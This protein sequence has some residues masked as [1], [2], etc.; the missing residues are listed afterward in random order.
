MLDIRLVRENPEIIEANLKKRFQEDKIR[1]LGELIAKDKKRREILQ[2]VETLKRDRNILTKEIS[3]LKSQK[4]PAEN[5][6]AE[7]KKVADRIKAM[8]EDL[9]K[10]AAECNGVLMRLPNILHE[11]VPSGK[12]EEGNAEVSRHGKMEKFPFKPKD[13]TDIALSLGCVDIERAAKITGARFYFLKNQL[14]LLDLALMRLAVDFLVKRGFSFVIPPHMMR[15][16][17]YEGVVDLTDFEEVLYK[18]ENEDLYLIATSEHPLTAQHMDETLVDL[19]V[20]YVGLSTNFRKEAGA[21]GKD[22]KGIFRVHQFNKAEQIVICRPEDSWPFHEQ[23]IKNAEEFLRLLEIPY[24][25][26]L[27]C[28]GESGSVAA[29]KYD[30]EVWL[31]A[32]QRFREV[33]SCSN[34]TDYQARRLN[35]KYREKEG[36]APAG[37][38][39]TLNSTLVTDRVLVAILENNQQEDGSVVVPKALQPYCGFEKIQK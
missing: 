9:E 1:M 33:V 22:T 31:P 6:L 25:K 11:S 26:L 28:S 23:L 4:K 3:E 14:A 27:M 12:G 19:P 38:V 7:V 13:H 5:K 2:E 37:F 36:E 39:H 16:K 18:I 15:R 34:C 10:L 17:P 21:H 35:I 32:Q 20:K 29:K 30:L 8:D 24:R